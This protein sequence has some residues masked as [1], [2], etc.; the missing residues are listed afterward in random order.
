MATDTLL[1]A[2]PPAAAGTG[3]ALPAEVTIYV[4]A[5]LLPQ[6][7]AWLD[8]PEAPATLALDAAG[9]DQV[10]AAGLQ[11][12]VSLGLGLAQRDRR[13]RLVAPGTALVDGCRQ[14]GLLAWLHGVTDGEPAR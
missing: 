1:D 2:P 10:D 5:D 13:L 3:P 14:L 4:V 9:V 11:L 6:W 12:L 8:E 7:L